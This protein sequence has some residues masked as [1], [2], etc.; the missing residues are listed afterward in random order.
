M[1]KKPDETNIILIC[2]QIL[3]WAILVTIISMTIGEI[4]KIKLPDLS[5]RDLIFWFVE[6]N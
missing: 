2:W 1:M 6:I 5:D 4:A 3:S